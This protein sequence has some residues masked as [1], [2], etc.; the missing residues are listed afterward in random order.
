MD[1]HTYG[2]IFEREAPRSRMSS[3]SS[4]QFRQSYNEDLIAPDIGERDDGDAH[5]STFTCANFMVD[6]GIYEDFLLLVD[7][8]GL[9]TYINDES[10]QYALLTKTFVESFSFNNTIFKPNV[11]FKIYNK[12]VTLSLSRFCEILGIPTIGTARKI[13]DTP[14]DLLEL[15]R[16]VTNDDDR[17]SQRGKIRNIQL[18]AIRYFTYYPATSILGR[19]N[20]SNISH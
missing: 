4:T 7:R 3:R 1:N 16:G 19:E 12:S 20:T 15:Y 6:A 11:A 10:E 18:P 9:T 2:E 5:P 17:R 13:K 14:A 8:V